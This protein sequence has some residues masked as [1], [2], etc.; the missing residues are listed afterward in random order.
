MIVCVSV[1]GSTTESAHE[2]V[3]FWADRSGLDRMPSSVVKCLTMLSATLVIMNDLLPI[4]SISAFQ[5]GDVA[6]VW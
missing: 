5:S 3:E 2:F 6:N 1:I 4:W